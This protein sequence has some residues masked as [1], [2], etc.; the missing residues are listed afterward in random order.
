MTRSRL[1]PRLKVLLASPRGF[2]AGVSR[3]IETVEETLAKYGAPV[4]VRHAIV[5]NAHVVKRLAAMGAIFVEE[6]DDVPD[7]RP[8][9][10]SAHGSPVSAHVDAKDR[11]I[12]P[13]DAVCP[14]VLKVH[15]QVKKY[16]AE[17]YHVLVVGHQGH[18]EVIGIMGQADLRS[19]TLIENIA[20]AK[21]FSAPASVKLAYVTQT[22]LSIDD[23]K[24]IVDTLKT[25]FPNLI[26]PRKKDI[27]FAT[28]NRQTAVKKIATRADTMFV[29]GSATSS[30]TMRLIDV[31]EQCGVPNAILVDDPKTVDLGSL[32]TTKVIGISAGASA[33]EDLVEMLL[34]RL[35]DLFTLAIE[36]VETAREDVSFKP[37][38]LNAG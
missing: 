11:G 3:A 36:T 17:G 31:A 30:N 28:E 14:L 38:A 19:F 5:H 1:R 23:T 37:P 22:T 8:L 2:C 24:Q 15:A 4:Y 20:D 13:I 7:D 26:G 6:V 10:F 32:D 33:P 16:A 21:S 18:P 9:V 35:A 34:A 25:R 12:R 29:I 27:C